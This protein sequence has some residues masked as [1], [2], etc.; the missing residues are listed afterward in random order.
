[1]NTLSESN[2]KLFLL[3][4]FALIYR[5]Y[6]AFIKNPRYNSK[7]L[8]TS[9]MLG[10]TNTLVE[11]IE[12]EKPTHLAVIFDPEGPTFRNEMYKEYKANRPPMPEDLKKS[13]PYIHNILK[14]MNICDIVVKGYEADDI[15]GT[16]SRKAEQAG[17]LT[18]MMTPDKDY[19]QLVTDRVFMYKP[20][21]SG[22]ELEIWGVDEV[23]DNMGVDNPEQVIDLLGLMGDASDNIPGCPGI[24]PKTAQKFIQAYGGIDGLY[25]NT[26]KLKGKQK[27]KVIASEEQVRLSR[28]L[29]T[30]SMDVP[31]DF[32]E[33]DCKLKS[34]NNSLLKEVF[35]DLEFFTLAK[36]LINK[37]SENQESDASTKADTEEIKEKI[38]L[39]YNN[40]NTDTKLLRQNLKAD[41]C[42]HDNFTYKIELSDPS[43]IHNSAIKSL[44]FSFSDDKAFYIELSG[45][46]KQD[47][48]IVN[49]FKFI[50]EDKNITKISY[51]VKHDIICLKSYDIHLAEN[52]FDISIAHYLI[53]PDQKHDF[54][55]ITNTY[56]NYKS[57]KEDKSEENTQ[58]GL[59]FEEDNE[60]NDS[61][62]EKVILYRELHKKLSKDITTKELDK[63]Y[64]D[65]EL[66]LVFVLAEMES[67]GVKLD[68]KELK[69][70]SE[71][72][73]NKIHNLEKDIIE[74]ADCEFNVGSPKQLG[75]V[76]FEKMKLDAKAKKTKSGQ[77]STS[78]AVL[79]KLAKKH[80]II[81]KILEFRG[82]KKLVSTYIDP[83]PSYINNKTGRIHTNFNQTEA[84][85]GRLSSNNPNLQNIPIR[86][87]DGRKVRKA[88]ST[89]SDEYIFL[90]ADY[91][92]IELRL[93]AHISQDKNM[94]EAFNNAEDFHRATAAKIYK[95]SEE[96]VNRDMRTRA[97]T[98]NFGIVYGISAFGLADRLNISRK[99]G[100]ELIDGYFDSYPGVKIFMD[101][102]I[103]SAR[104]KGYVSTI[105]NRRRNLRDINSSNAIVRGIAERN[106]IN[107]PVQ[108]SAADVIKI[109][110]I[111]IHNKMQEEGLKSKMV[112][113]VHDELNFECLIS[114]KEALENI[115][116]TEMEAAADLSVKLI[117]EIGSGKNWLEA[118]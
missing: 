74:L 118:H 31:V 4:A 43:D 107:A 100:K 81:P 72:L 61:N 3:D 113:Q 1:M 58:I 99:E 67:N 106:A 89:E 77:Y 12:K 30:I 35:D 41:L 39:D 93:I 26:D 38:V 86:T 15:I 8:N 6:Y 29:A 52:I 69:Q 103:E 62:C 75:E 48:E 96:E 114:E 13:I 17:Y 73:K 33:E 65:I 70:N 55:Y 37:D 50:F 111:N 18:Y 32:N 2:K 102:A 101:K 51:N 110:M 108:G 90:S 88:F 116:R 16:L 63:I 71:E 117:A 68:T 27:E 46:K 98:A 19:A 20:K 97:K 95:L 79:S 54:E 109:A 14:A 10:F 59:L 83:L 34:F 84:A 91:S 9:A 87:E 94:I 76:L 56:L 80:E 45:D 28:T 40:Y 92:Q 22:K 60:I 82:L 78:E 57:E 44:Y 115:I 47:F 49:E 85:T 112:L 5:S 66:P 25:Q 42:I 21:R 105:F 104:E 24:G 64:T 7:G 53:F 23:K 11:V 36:K